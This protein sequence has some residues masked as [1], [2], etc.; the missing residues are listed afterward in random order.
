MKFTERLQAILDW[1]ASHGAR[2]SRG[3]FKAPNHLSLAT[4]R[5]TRG[6]SVGE[7]IPVVVYADEHFKHQRSQ[8][9][10]LTPQGKLIGDI[11]LER[12]SKYRLQIHE[13][14]ETILFTEDHITP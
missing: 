6:E 7:S 2:L 5:F 3:G 12:D 9:I 8:P 1:I 14:D 13:S 10:I 11:W 4:V